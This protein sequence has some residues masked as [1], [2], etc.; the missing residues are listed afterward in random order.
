MLLHA[1]NNSVSGMYLK[2]ARVKCIDTKPFPTAQY[3]P[4][5]LGRVADFVV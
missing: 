5:S 3:K 1:G 2:T 4:S